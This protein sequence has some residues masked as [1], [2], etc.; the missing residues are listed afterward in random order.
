MLDTPQDPIRKSVT[1]P[2]PP[3]DAFALFTAG[4]NRWWPM[5]THSLSSGEGDASVR[6]EPRVGG[7]ILETLPDGTDAPWATVTTWEPGRRFAARWYV[8][9]S[10]DEATTLEVTFT[11]TEAGTRVDLTHG[12]FDAHGSTGPQACA[13][14]TKGW[15]HVLGQCFHS[16]CEMAA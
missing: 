11:A 12:G 6:V 5:D 7:R 8:G 3:D 13:N 1:V 9:R 10:E 14:Y 4:I 2:L 16:Q 15:D